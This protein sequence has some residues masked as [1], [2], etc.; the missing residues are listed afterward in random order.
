MGNIDTSALTGWASPDAVETAAGDIKDAGQ[1]I[2]NTASDAKSTWAGLSG[3]YEA[4]EQEIVLSAFDDVATAGDDVENAAI[5]VRDALITFASEVRTLMPERNRLL[6]EA[7]TANAEPGD[8]GDN[9]PGTPNYAGQIST[10]AGKYKAAEDTCASTIL[11][12]HPSWKG[13][14]ASGPGILGTPLVGMGYSVGEGIAKRTHRSPLWVPKP[15]ASKFDPVPGAPKFG[16]GWDSRPGNVPRIAPVQDLPKLGPTSGAPN[17]LR[18]DNARVDY[19]HNGTPYT[20]VGGIYLETGRATVRSNPQP[21]KANSHSRPTKIVADPS[22]ANTP[23]WAKLGGKGLAGVGTAM[24]LW[25]AGA[26]RWRQDLA[27]HPDWGTTERTVSAATDVAVV[28]GAAVA[29]AAAG[30]KVG[31]MVGTAIGGPVGLAVGVVV[32]AGLGA[33]GGWIGKEFGEEIREGIDGAV[34]ATAE[35][36]GELW[37]SLWG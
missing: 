2:Q 9:V 20:K 24:T 4:P 3:A 8:P 19:V 25:D 5:T 32:G 12:A 15:G 35:K 10:L 6:D 21:I 36:A 13:T 1:A 30:A 34:D 22:V 23:R 26:S 33:V 29:G 18:L 7:A 27:E 16:T 28:G 14:A 37:D 11:G 31:A 17:P